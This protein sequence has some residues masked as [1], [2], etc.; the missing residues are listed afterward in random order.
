MNNLKNSFEN[1]RKDIFISYARTDK[2]FVQK[3]KNELQNKG[4]TIW[5][6][7]SSIAKTAPFLEEIYAG[8][9][10]A[11]K[12][13]A[14]I[15]PDF[16]HS[17]YCKIETD[18]AIKRGKKL[19]PILHAPIKSENLHHH[20]ASI[21]WIEFTS[22]DNFE[23]KVQE[24]VNAI[25]LDLS[26]AKNSARYLQLALDWQ[27]QS[28]NLLSGTVLIEAEKWLNQNKENEINVTNLHTQFIL[29]S[30][31]A[32]RWRRL[33]VMAV[34]GVI[35]SPILYFTFRILLTTPSHAWMY[36]DSSSREISDAVVIQQ[37]DGTLKIRARQ[38][39]GM[40]RNISP[41]ESD[42][43]VFE[44]KKSILDIT[45]DGKIDAELPY[46]FEYIDSWRL[47]VNDSLT[48]KQKLLHE[49]LKENFIFFDCFLEQD[50]IWGTMLRK[51]VNASK[52]LSKNGTYELSHSKQSNKSYTGPCWDALSEITF[53]TFSDMTEYPRKM[54]DII[55]FLLNNDS[56]LAFVRIMESG[57]VYD[58][59][60]VSMLS[61]DM[62]KSWKVGQFYPRSL[63]GNSLYFSALGIE[64]IAVI[65]DSDSLLL[66][67]SYNLSDD[68]GAPSGASGM[69]LLSTDKGLS[70]Q[71]M[72]LPD[73]YSITES[74]SG[75][76]TAT[77]DEKIFILSLGTQNSYEGNPTPKILLTRDAGSSWTELKEGLNINQHA[78]IQ[79]LGI[80]ENESVVGFTDEKKII[81]YRKLSLL[82]RLRGNI[83]LYE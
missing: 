31:R 34:M 56:L 51:N 48:L 27:N 71:E 13:V 68:M 70:W 2:D 60:T 63:D 57:E 47:A 22:S 14:I 64:S 65:G 35:L 80:L 25:N 50:A 17:R 41:Y 7:E 62:G 72:E 16:N 52:V 49:E 11:A 54:T 66:A 76:T 12:F 24:T 38:N 53:K 23:K 29:K 36:T 26:V 44:T 3:L 55:V 42:G 20:L 33:R 78:K 75:L 4:I 18:Y 77:F 81:I 43:D 46:A 39:D 59:G 19:I 61:V 37:K 9:D 79:V 73:K 21:N 6:D 28:G 58:A 45:A 15:S 32:I 5:I 69:F 82:E 30:R 74:F 8:I 40:M 67:S 10:G 83:G 1:T